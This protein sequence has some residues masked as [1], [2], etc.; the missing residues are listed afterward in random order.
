MDQHHPSTLRELYPDS[1]DEQLE[2]A[3]ATLERF[4]AVM[5]RIAERLKD[6]GCDLSGPDLTASETEASI[7]AAKVE[8]TSL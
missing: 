8:S 6:G 4:L 2:E 5:Q 3:E 7:P 1:S